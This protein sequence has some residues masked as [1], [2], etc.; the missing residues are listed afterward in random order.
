MVKP[1]AR[2]WLYRNHQRAITVYLV[3]SMI[4][5]VALCVAVALI[6]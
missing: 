2:N 3:A 1:T 5:L 4:A 6:D